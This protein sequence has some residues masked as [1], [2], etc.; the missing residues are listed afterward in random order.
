MY[1]QKCGAPVDDLRT[2]CR[3]CGNPPLHARQYT[4][5][6]FD[7]DPVFRILLPVGRSWWAIAAGY[8]GLFAVLIFPAPLALVLGIVALRDLKRHPDKFGYGR[9][10]F[11]TIAGGL[12]TVVLIGGLVAIGYTDILR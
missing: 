10:I 7:S 5:S 6:D 9:A 11:G 4:A 1:C 2:T 12:G 8:A 3:R